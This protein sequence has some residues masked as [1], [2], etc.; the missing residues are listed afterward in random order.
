MARHAV[1]KGGSSDRKL[2]ELIES[3]I[4]KKK[5]V[6]NVYPMDFYYLISE[7]S[8]LGRVSRVNLNH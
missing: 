3:L 5:C 6:S 4:C 7:R 1:E 8:F 2:N